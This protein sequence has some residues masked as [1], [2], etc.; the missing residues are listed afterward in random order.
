MTSTMQVKEALIASLKRNADDCENMERWATPE[1]AP[2]LREAAAALAVQ[3]SQAQMT[4]PSVNEYVADYEYRGDQDY[5]PSEG[6]QAMIEDA[7]EGYFS[8]L[9]APSPA[10]LDPVTVEAIERQY[11]YTGEPGDHEAI[12]AALRALIGHPAPTGDGK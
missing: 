7:I 1:L 10:A 6:E 3:S 11:F 4:M 8:L 5:V 9:T 12:K 2:L